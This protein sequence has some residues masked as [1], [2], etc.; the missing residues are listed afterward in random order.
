MKS[1][2]I[3]VGLGMVVVLSGLV[4]ALMLMSPE[5]SA[6]LM[7]EM[8]DWQV[9][10]RV[11]KGTCGVEPDGS[12]RLAGVTFELYGSMDGNKLTAYLDGV[13]RLEVTDSKLSC[14]RLGVEVFGATATYD[15]LKAWELP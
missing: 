14:G 4:A 12:E 13:K 2:Q 8:A 1:K 9:S 10:G 6:A 3:V 15:D 7:P 5:S 11:Y